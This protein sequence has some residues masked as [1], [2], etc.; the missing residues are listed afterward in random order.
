L[1]DINRI[2]V[3]LSRTLAATAAALLIVASPFARAQVT[4][5]TRIVVK[6]RDGALPS[7]AGTLPGDLI[8]QL[9]TALRTPFAPSGRTRDRAFRLTLDPPLSIDEARAALNRLRQAREVLYAGVDRDA[10]RLARPLAK[11]AANAPPVRALIVKYRDPAVL[12]AATANGSFSAS[13]SARLSAVAG[14]PVAFRRP[15]AVGATL[16]ALMKVV[17][18][19][20]ASAIAAALEQDPA[21]EYAEPD[22]LRFPMLIPND[23]NWSS[24]WDLMAPA[25]EIGGANLP[26]AWDIT[27]GAAGVNVAVID[28][29][30]L[31]H[32]DLSGRYIGGYDFVHDFV[33]GNDNQPGQPANCLNTHPL[34][35]LS[36]P[37]VDD[38]DADPTD[39]GDWVSAADA[40]GTTFDGWLAGC[41]QSNSSWH[42]THVA[43]TIAA[44][45]NNASGVAGINWVGKV[46]P[47]RALGKCGG[48][49]SDITDAIVWAVNGAVSGVPANPN[50]ARVLNLSLGGGGSCSAAEQNAINVALAANA[51]V[52][53]AAG[54]SN[55]DAANSSPGNCN[56]VITVAATQR[57]GYKANYSNFGASVEISA[58]GGGDKNPNTGTDF[59]FSTLNNGTTSA[60]PAGYV[61]AGYE[62]TSMAT[63]HVAGI[64]SLVL[65][66]N[67]AL[68]P[69]QVLAKLQTTARAFPAGGPACAGA[70]PDP[71]SANWFSCHCTTAIC[72]AGM[73]DAGRAVLATV[74]ATTSTAVTSSQ[75]PSTVGVSVTFTATV[76][77]GL[78][79]TGTA[80]FKDGAL[81]IAGCNNASVAT[82]G[83]TGT[84]TCMT[85]ALTQ[86]AH[87]IT[88]AYSGDSN[89]QSSTS[90][91]FSQTVN[92]VGGPQNV[93]LA[94]NGGVASASSTFSAS[95]PVSAVN[96]GDRAGIGWGSGG[97]WN[98]ATGNMYPDWVQIN[99]SGQKT[100]DH[101]IVYTL[102]DNYANPVDPPDTLTFTQYGVTSFQVQSWNG[103]A[104]VNQGAAVSGNNLVK[105]TVNFTA[106]STDRIRVNITGALAGY[107]RITEIEAWTAS[108][109]AAATTTTLASSANPAALNAT[110]TLT[111]T[112]N[113]TAAPTGLVAFTDNGVSI[114]SCAAVALTGGGN[115]PTAQCSWTATP[116]G[117]HSIV[118]SY[119]GDASNQAST[120]ATLSQVVN[121]GGGQINV[122]LASNG[123]VASASSTFSASFPVS[124]INNGDRAGV[125]WGSGGGWN[126]A[127]GNA[128]PDWVQ[129][130]FNGQKT[131]DHVIVYTLQDNYANPVD[132]PDTLTFT[133]YGVTAFQV[134]GWNGS[135]WV[136]LGSAVSG[137]NLV[138]RTVNFS[139]FN[140]DRIRVNITGAMASYSRIVE[141]EAWGVPVAGQINV[142]LASNGGVASA[143]STFSASFPASAINNGDRAGVG[144]GSGGG[145]NDATGNA[146]PDWVQINF[147]GQK[148]IDHVIVYTLQDNYANPVDPPDTLTFTQYGVTAFQ[149]QSWN[150]S[151][152]VNQ[153][154]AVSGNNLVKRTVNFTA[155]TTDRIRV[156]ITGALAGY[157]RITEIEAWGN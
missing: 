121:A 15:L 72:G 152:W 155:V 150:G 129:I 26:P 108:G 83:D 106:V 143:S 157:S 34:N 57:Q 82:V 105:R 117:T 76:T 20:E 59:I 139:A 138:K 13:E 1:R 145:W 77:G 131:I 73:I 2:F 151:A 134:Q 97:G 144:W 8:Q 23:T 86:G 55:D 50:P 89:N 32:P 99:F 96:N 74:G 123:G 51:V 10:I 63:P 130:N 91:V 94:A 102:Q 40:A 85:S 69:A 98:D 156:N 133:Q 136:N 80:A 81:T 66:V 37:C 137:N 140:T 41:P 49:T 54:N 101:V 88:A 33:L 43:G 17:S 71:N 92:G 75:N 9:G 44:A 153:G 87:S 28:T 45:S 16:V 22:R 126:D 122:A 127:T 90:S 61:I 64:A 65:S 132:P 12:A 100:I 3:G 84:A 95:F 30:I 46:V 24:Q 58:P 107:S 48:Y 128:Y 113:G 70:P 124:S 154:A 79:P 78:V 19:A 110:V 104:W 119:A 111:A 146:Y 11:N 147:S 114:A 135:A 103:S 148:T 38:R 68:T 118:A 62:G 29:G 67:P 35:P 4:D 14:Q 18:D 141:V 27:T 112:V 5:V 31:P 42:G 120:S 116:A 39:P 21:I 93:A 6:Y 142:A 25:S 125:G 60:N 115:S 56:G 149:V 52:A 47:L 7:G 53:I 109:G 36:P